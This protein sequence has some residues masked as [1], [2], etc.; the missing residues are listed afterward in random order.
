M[1][2]ILGNKLYVDLFASESF[3]QF[4]TN[5]SNYIIFGIHISES[6][7]YILF[8]PNSVSKTDH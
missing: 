3:L 8:S 2:I 1:W 7:S 6:I 4:F 5:L